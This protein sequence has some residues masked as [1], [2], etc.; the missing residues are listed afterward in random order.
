MKFRFILLLL[1]LCHLSYAETA[2]YKVTSSGVYLGDMS[3]SKTTTNDVVEIK[4]VSDVKV[5]LFLSIDLKYRL[6]CTYKNGNLMYSSVTT[7]VNGSK[8]SS[9]ITEKK[10]QSYLVT[11]DG[12]VSKYLK[13]INYSGGLL[14]FDEPN[15]QK[16]LYSEFNGYDKVIKSLAQSRYLVTDN[17]TGHKSTYEYKNGT[18]ILATIE[19]TLMTFKM[20]KY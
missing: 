18:L 10:G 15:N 8:H 2:K 5:K 19:H 7:F 11:E 14:Y 13:V 9:V 17:N 12:H 16:T 6:N 3:V 4:I 1:F 20:T